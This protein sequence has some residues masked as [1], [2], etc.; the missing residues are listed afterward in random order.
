[1][2]TSVR[3]F[4][5]LFYHPRFYCLLRLL[6]IVILRAYPTPAR[7]WP[8]KDWEQ[9]PALNFALQDQEAKDPDDVF[10]VVVDNFV[11]MASCRAAAIRF[12]KYIFDVK[13][14]YRKI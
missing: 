13:D 14:I 3:K 5:G 2:F 7:P 10:G 9:Q 6:P 11:E 12:L 1:L 4:K 8:M